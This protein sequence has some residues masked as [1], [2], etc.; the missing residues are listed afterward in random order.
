MKKC[1]YDNE[2]LICLN[3]LSITLKKLSYSLN[4]D[5]QSSY[6][7]D[8]KKFS[9]IISYL[10]GEY[11]PSNKE[12]ENQFLRS[13]ISNIVGK[14]KTTTNP[15]KIG[16]YGVQ[17]IIEKIGLT[18]IKPKSVNN[19]KADG[20]IKELD[21]FIEV[22]TKTY[23][24]PGTA[25]EK[26]DSIP[27][28]Y[29]IIYENTGKSVLVIFCAHQ[30]TEK[31]G[32]L[33]LEAKKGIGSKY[34]INWYKN[35]INSGI[36]IDW[37]T[38]NELHSWIL[39]KLFLVKNNNLRTLPHKE[40]DI[41]PIVKW[42]GGKRKLVPE[43]IKK[44]NKIQYKRYIEPFL[45][46]GSVFFSLCP[47]NAII[48]DI[49]T[50]LIEMFE[51]IKKSPIKLIEE[52]KKMNNYNNKEDYYNIRKLG[53]QDK[54]K[55]IQSTRFIYLNKT[56]FRGLYREN[57]KGWFNV[58]FGNYTNPLICDEENILNISNFLNNNTILI[59]NLDYK[60]ILEM[61]KEGDLIYLDPP[62]YPITTNQFTKYNSI[63]F[64]PDEHF[65]LISL[66]DEL[67]LKNVYFILSNSPA[68][69]LLKICTNY[70]IDI[71]N[72]KSSIKVYRKPEQK[73][74]TV[75]EVLIYN[76]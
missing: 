20:Y 40:I 71:F 73:N 32:K 6:K 75:E 23:H 30:S 47:K 34:L 11:I 9:L 58:P 33:I 38:Y 21:I 61:V 53:I 36:I 2:L 42:A 49:N 55:I 3:K 19:I 67:S 44:I 62:Y 57:S 50:Y 8:D 41:K 66:L 59:Y 22:K 37:I 5:I 68:K 76:F 69:E 39:N 65:E 31:N 63:D 56:C 13:D 45:G 43:I 10:N 28:K 16:E 70:N 17:Y 29:S 46:G 35:T 48:N 51:V 26:I 54:D 25:S 72:K 74:D 18:Y 1:I 52:L 4:I 12:E 24:T 14:N 60:K 27:R 64:T 7:T 15:G